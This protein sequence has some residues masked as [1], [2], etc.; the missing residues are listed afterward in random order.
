MGKAIVLAICLA[1]FAVAAIEWNESKRSKAEPTVKL[2]DQSP[3]LVHN[4]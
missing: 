2:N 1:L 3:T 4:Q